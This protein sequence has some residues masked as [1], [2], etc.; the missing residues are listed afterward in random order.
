M[1][2]LQP[3]CRRLPSAVHTGLEILH[4]PQWFCTF[5]LFFDGTQRPNGQGFAQTIQP[6]LPLICIFQTRT[7]KT[8]PWE[9]NCCLVIEMNDDFK[10]VTASTVILGDVLWW[11]IT[12]SPSPSL[13]CVF[14]SFTIP[15]FQNVAQSLSVMSR[16]ALECRTVTPFPWLHGPFSL[17]LNDF[18][19]CSCQ[20]SIHN[21][22]RPHPESLCRIFYK[23]SRG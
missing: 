21:I 19:F 13:G 5:E 10:R 18:I 22:G 6:R 7:K 1:S 16:A 4:C 11:L 3:I 12:N 14:V 9:V 20:S 15:V 23:S 8:Q 2:I 17:D